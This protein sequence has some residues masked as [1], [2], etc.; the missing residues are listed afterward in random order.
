MFQN[1]LIGLI[2]LYHILSWNLTST[3]QC[4]SYPYLL[5]GFN[6]GWQKL[7]QAVETLS[8]LRVH[9]MSFYG[10]GCEVIEKST[11]A[12]LGRFHLPPASLK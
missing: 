9:L 7:R 3:K 6:I 2:L 4:L 8:E 1:Y 12:L 5:K 11:P 10:Y